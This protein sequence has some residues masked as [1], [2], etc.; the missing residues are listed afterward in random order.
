MLENCDQWRAGFY[1]HCSALEVSEWILQCISCLRGGRDLRCDLDQPSRQS[2]P[3]P[4][5]CQ[6]PVPASARLPRHWAEHPHHALPWLGLHPRAL[7]SPLAGLIMKRTEPQF[8]GTE[9]SLAMCPRG[10]L[11]CA[12]CRVMYVDHYWL[13]PPSLFRPTSSSFSCS[14]WR[15]GPGEFEDP[16]QGKLSWETD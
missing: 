3:P 15:R 7:P 16:Y 12:F 1:V 13:S 14:W 10:S 8:K 5:T 4:H 9:R 2:S 6:E 11:L